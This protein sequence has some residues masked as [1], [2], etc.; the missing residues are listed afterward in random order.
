MFYR[1]VVLAV[2]LALLVA[3]CASVPLS[4]MWKLRNVDPIATDV[5]RIRV[6]V[7]APSYLRVVAENVRFEVGTV[8]KKTG[9]HVSKRLPL[10]VVDDVTENAALRKYRK[11]GFYLRVFR[12]SRA[13]AQSLR[14]YRRQFRELK[15]EFG[16]D[17]SGQL[18]ISA[19]GCEQPGEKNRPLPVTTFFRSAE[20]G[21]FVVLTSETDIRRLLGPSQ[22]LRTCGDRQKG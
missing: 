12:L 11:P 2:I 21:G 8:N 14:V 22:T 1:K 4:T 16:D 6:G 20:T 5:S 19:S 7:R 9:S 15:K 18:S 13:G 10:V 3:G 17:V